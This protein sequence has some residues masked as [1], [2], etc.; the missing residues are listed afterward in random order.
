MIKIAIPVNKNN[1]VD[2]HFGHCE[3]YKVITLG[4]NNEIENSE[5][6]ESPKGCGCKSNIAK[7]LADNGVSVMLAGGIGTGA[8]NKLN[9]AGIEVVRGCSG[10]VEELAKKYA[11]GEITD[12]GSNCNHHEHR[13]ESCDHH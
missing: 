10:D 4:K 7:T 1:H 9:E 13:H 6:M 5:I 11:N 3:A 8:V 12:N 2:G